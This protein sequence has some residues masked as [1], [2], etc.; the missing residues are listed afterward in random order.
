MVI[1]LGISGDRPEL[2]RGEE[3]PNTTKRAVAN[4]HRKYDPLFLFLRQK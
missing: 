2:R 1:E 3:S 4:G